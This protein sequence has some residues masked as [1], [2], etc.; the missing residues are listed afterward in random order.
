MTLKFVLARWDKVVIVFLVV[1]CFAYV[2]M[3]IRDRH[4]ETQVRQMLV[5]I[6]ENADGSATIVQVPIGCIDFGLHVIPAC[7]KAAQVLPESW[8]D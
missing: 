7:E 6:I 3:Q 1:L 4:H 2:Q 5:G 8:T